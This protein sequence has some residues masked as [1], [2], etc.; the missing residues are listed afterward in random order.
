MEKIFKVY[1]DGHYRWWFMLVNIKISN[2]L[3]EFDKEIYPLIDFFNQNRNKVGNVLLSDNN[4]YH[5]A[6]YVILPFVNL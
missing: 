5:Y 4:Y 2:I 3:N 1:I 6:A